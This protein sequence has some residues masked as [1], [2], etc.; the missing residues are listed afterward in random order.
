MVP[1]PYSLLIASTPRRECLI[2]SL[3]PPRWIES[4]GKDRLSR[5]VAPLDRPA[6]SRPYAA[7]ALPAPPAKDWACLRTRSTSAVGKR[8]LTC[9]FPWNHLGIRARDLHITSPPAHGSYRAASLEKQRP[10]PW[11]PNQPGDVFRPSAPGTFQGLPALSEGLPRDLSLPDGASPLKIGE[12]FRRRSE[13]LSKAKPQVAETSLAVR[14]VHT[15]DPGVTAARPALPCRRR[16]PPG[17]SPC[18]WRTRPRLAARRREAGAVA[19]I[20]A[21]SA[22]FVRRG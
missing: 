2:P 16:P 9:G 1:V 15:S 17:S 22:W 6:Q 21:L 12:D 14:R 19:G 10:V 4:H 13:A 7:E 20:R 8:G 18:G 11:D 5:Q 3:D